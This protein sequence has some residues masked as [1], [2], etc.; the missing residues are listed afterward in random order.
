MTDNQPRLKRRIHWLIGVNTG[1]L[2]DPVLQRGINTDQPVYKQLNS[3]LAGGGGILQRMHYRPYSLLYF[4]RHFIS[5]DWEN[6]VHLLL[7]RHRYI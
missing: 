5:A 3:P 6:I 7:V 2:Y 1:E 4:C